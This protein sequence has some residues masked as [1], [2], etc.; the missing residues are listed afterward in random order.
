MTNRG[1]IA[2][3]WMVLIA[4]TLAT[5]VTGQG[6]QPY[7]HANTDRFIHQE[8]PMLPPPANVVFSDSDFGSK[9]VRATDATTNFVHPGSYLRP[10]GSGQANEWSADTKKFYVIG[11]GG[12]NFAFAFDPS[13][14]AISSLPNAGAEK[15]L[16]LP[17][18][19]G[20]SF[21]LTDPDLIY[22]TTNDDP[23]TITS[24]RFSTG[25]SSTVIDT[26]NCGVQPPLGSGGS[27]LSDGDV[28]PSLDDSRMSISE[29]GPQFG[30]DMFVIVY[31]KNLGC[32]WYNT[33]TGHIG[34]QWG[35]SGNATVGGSYLIRHAYLARSGNYVYILTDVGVWYT[36]NL[37]TLTVEACANGS[38][39]D[40]AG[41]G[42]VGYNSYINSPGMYDDMYLVKR[43]LGNISQFSSLFYPLP[44][45]GNWGQAKHFTWSNVNGKD[46]VPVCGSTY[47]YYDETLGFE[48]PFAGEIFCI[49]TDGLASTVWRFAHNRA[50]YISPFFQTQPLGNVSRGGRFFLFG[51][52]WDAQL[53]LAP[54]GT[55]RSDVFIVRLD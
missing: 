55:P 31:D 29:G 24:Y 19:P 1:L 36:W 8:T 46:S 20:P 17:L 33:Q 49:E 43:P 32:R 11:D 2:F 44:T 54:D 52:D 3:S 13:T 5:R 25:V 12:W 34:G 4:F 51:S 15:G 45:P 41:Y 30:A 22:G 37:A 23:L 40:C 21:S 6:I 42:V 47:G 9:M 53:G 39:P 38:G 18:R 35:L 10:E 16:I 27:V 14:M 26:R 28:T 7:P 48:E 50:T